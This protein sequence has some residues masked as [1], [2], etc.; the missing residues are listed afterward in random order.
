[1]KL[2]IV[3]RDG[4]LARSLAERAGAG[5]Q[6]VFL[7]RDALDLRQPATI[8]EAIDLERPDALVNTA[9]YT[10]VDAAEDDEDGAFAVNAR[11]PGVL[12]TTAARH[13]LPFVHVST[14]Y[15]FDGSGSS[16]LDESTS[17][18]PIGAYGRSKLAG[19]EAV[20]AADGDALVIR[21]AWVYSPFGK[22]F[23]KTMLALAATRDE[24]SVVADQFGTP[25]NALDL[26]DGIL[27]ALETRRA[28]GSFP[29]PL[30][31]LAGQGSASW[32][33]VASEVMSASAALGAASAVVRPID[34]AGFP[35][36]ARRPANSRLDS[37]LF[38]RTFGYVAPDWRQSV[39][40]VVARLVTEDIA[41]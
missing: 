33:D 1:M 8:A 25:T 28:R 14:D 27:A 26:A 21:T 23:V 2:L 5:W 36:R 20:A 16:M 6:C 18:C 22:N 35:T 19:E 13:R 3:G 34:T 15:V 37:T 17:T 39:H 41:R 24:V 7:G 30:A 29:V 9:A 11:A 32:F 12:A 38:A 4:Q 40:A 10:A 31:H